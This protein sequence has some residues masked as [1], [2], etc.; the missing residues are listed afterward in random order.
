MHGYF[1]FLAAATL[2]FGL[3]RG[4]CS[5]G[6]VHAGGNFRRVRDCKGGTAPTLADLR[7]WSVDADDDDN[8]L[9]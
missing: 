3:A 8:K 2:Y 1:F 6:L 9:N 4:A 7:L 5:P